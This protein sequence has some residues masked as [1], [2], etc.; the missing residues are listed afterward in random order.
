M[1][2]EFPSFTHTSAPEAARP[3]LSSSLRSFGAIPAPLARYASSPLMLNTALANLRAFEESSLSELEREILAVTMGRANGC[4][5]CVSM[6]LNQLGRLRADPELV[7][8][9]R[10]GDALP[11]PRLEA[12]RQF[13]LNA[14]EK[15]GD[16]DE[17]AFASFREHGFD[18]R[19]A[20]DTLLGIAA[21]TLTTFANRLT[22]T[23][24]V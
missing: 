23:S 4:Q 17:S 3:A 19:Q 7:R 6:H 13:V 24:E 1:S 9:L 15:R 20:L 16:V 2:R 22:E 14:L 11:S 12:L 18:H 10:A 21:Y 8:A 5:F